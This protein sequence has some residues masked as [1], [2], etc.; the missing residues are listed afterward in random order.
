MQALAH[1]IVLFFTTQILLKGFLS[2]S[3]LL[4]L[5]LSGG[6]QS[7][8]SSTA[9]TVQFIFVRKKKEHETEHKQNKKIKWFGLVTIDHK[10]HYD[11]TLHQIG[12]G[13][14]VCLLPGGDLQ[15]EWWERRGGRRRNE[16][17]ND[18][19]TVFHSEQISVSLAWNCY[20]MIANDISLIQV[21]SESLSS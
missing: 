5:P 14:M 1:E 18:A 2:L 21:A 9:V 7:Q 19:I 3:G 10:F 11:L 16:L 4:S 20:A 15:Q 6:K 12:S 13:T 17:N 8:K